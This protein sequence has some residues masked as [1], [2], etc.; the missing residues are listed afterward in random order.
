MAHESRSERRKARYKY[1]TGLGFSTEDARRLRDQS[2]RNIESNVKRERRRIS[3]KPRARR[4]TDEQDRLDSIQVSSTAT[5][6]ETRER[7]F[8]SRGERYDSFSSWSKIGFPPWAINRISDYNKSRRLS[9]DDSF[10]YRRFYFWYV[11]RVADFENEFFADRGDS[12]IRNLRGISLTARTD[13][14]RVA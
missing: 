1:L 7:R 5:L 8:M 14:R 11:E 12:G 3:R 2:G 6:L 4:S 9:R 10:G 13:I